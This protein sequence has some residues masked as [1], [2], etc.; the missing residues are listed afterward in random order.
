MLDPTALKALQFLP[1]AGNYFL[2]DAGQLSNFVVNRSAVQ[3]ET[4]L[5]LQTGSSDF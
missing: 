5:M 2:N 4:R 3:N 1:R